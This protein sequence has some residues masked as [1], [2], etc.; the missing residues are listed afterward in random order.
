MIGVTINGQP[1]EIAAGTTLQALIEELGLPADGIASAIDRTV[2]PRSTYA[3]TVLTDGMII[4]IIR[5]VGGG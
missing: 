4:E 1:R 3:D 5:A 2:V